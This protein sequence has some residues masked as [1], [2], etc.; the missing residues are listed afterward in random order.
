[1]KNQWLSK[2]RGKQT[3][4]NHVLDFSFWY[5][6]ASADALGWLEATFRG[7]WRLTEGGTGDEDAPS[8]LRTDMH[9]QFSR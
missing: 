7:V 5:G 4:T 6:P 1:M 3:K 8:A 2:E 9:F